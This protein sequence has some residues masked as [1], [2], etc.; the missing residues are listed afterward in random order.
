M[1]QQRERKDSQASSVQQV[2]DPVIIVNGDAVE[3]AE[4][5]PKVD[6]EIDAAKEKQE[7]VK[8]AEQAA[9]QHKERMDSW[10]DQIVAGG[11]WSAFHAPKDV[12][13]KVEEQEQEEIQEEQQAEPE[14]LDQFERRLSIS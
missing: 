4:E 8:P 13:L 12:D 14:P 9:P 11:G 2:E 10:L 1:A 7:V 6:K 3:D 5:E